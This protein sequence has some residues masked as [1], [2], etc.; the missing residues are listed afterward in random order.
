MNSWQA[1][2][3]ASNEQLCCGTHILYVHYGQRAGGCDISKSAPQLWMPNQSGAGQRL[4]RRKKHV[5]AAQPPDEQRRVGPLATLA[6]SNNSTPSRFHS[7]P[8]NARAPASLRPPISSVTRLPCKLFVRPLSFSLSP[9]PESSCPFFASF[10]P[11][12]GRLCSLSGGA[13]RA[14]SLLALESSLFLASLSASLTQ[15]ILSHLHSSLHRHGHRSGL[16]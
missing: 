13:A 14:S 9:P 16:L 3:P 5:T 6:N 7:T 8:L 12:L 1:P 4:Q 10:P 2:V 11:G 15:A